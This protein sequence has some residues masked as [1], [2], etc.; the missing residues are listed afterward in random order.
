MPQTHRDRVLKL[1]RRAG[2][3]RVRDL[4]KRGLHP[5]HLRRLVAAGLVERIERGMYAPA[6]WEP[7][8]NHSLAQ[9]S[10]QV[11]RGVICLMSALRFHDVGTQSPFEVW[12][13]VDRRARRPRVRVPKLRIVRFSGA[14][15][16]AGIERHRIEGADVRIY[17]VSKTVAD[18]FKYRNKIGLDIALEALREGLRQRRFTRDEL[19]GHA[20][21]C[22][23]A[24]VMRP[25]LESV[26]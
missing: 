6:G 22:R 24:G 1:V 16:T 23:V 15:L 7:S 14:A 19:W 8:P 5:E 2:I 17:S 9:A 12:M 18:C 10:K 11:P 25:Y 3:V 13:A 26:T 20:K 21:T 4:R